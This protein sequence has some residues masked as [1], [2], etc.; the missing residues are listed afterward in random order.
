MNRGHNENL[1]PQDNAIRKTIPPPPQ[2]H[3]ET[4]SDPI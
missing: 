3:L 2:D 4:V 1:V